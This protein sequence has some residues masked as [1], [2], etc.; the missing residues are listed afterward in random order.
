MIYKW[1]EQFSDGWNTVEDAPRRGRPSST[2]FH[3]NIEYVKKAID[4][5]RRITVRELEEKLGIAKTSIYLILTEHLG[6]TRVVARLVPK[7][8][9]EQQKLARSQVCSTLIKAWQHEKDYLKRIVTGDESW[10]HFYEPESKFQSSKWKRK[11]KVPPIKAKSVPSAGKRMVTIFWDYEG[12]LQ[13]EWLPEKT[14]INSD[15]YITILRNLRKRIKKERRGKLASGILLQHDNATP[16]TSERTKA[17][18]SELGFELVPHPP[19]SPDLAPSDYWLFGEMK[20]PLRGKRFS[21]FDELQT[22]VNTWVKGT[23]K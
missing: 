5:D 21:N 23:P 13:I 11:D 9:S 22:A 19:Y 15:Y 16:H 1:I 20:R 18:I 14:T 10:F 8:L 17:I 12:I 6:M 7:L 4:E 2:I 3:G